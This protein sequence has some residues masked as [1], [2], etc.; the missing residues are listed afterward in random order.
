MF[1]SWSCF[2]SAFWQ[3]VRV[4]SHDWIYAKEDLCAS[5][6][7]PRERRG[8]I[9]EGACQTAPDQ[10]G[11]FGA[12]IAGY[13]LIFYRQLVEVFALDKFTPN[14]IT[15]KHQPEALCIEWRIESSE[16]LDAS[17]FVVA[18]SGEYIP[19]DEMIFMQISLA[20]PHIGED[21]PS[22]AAYNSCQKSQQR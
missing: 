10:W 8:D 20:T 17:A 16:I 19:A 6:Y 12:D 5:A 4:H 15:L 14:S 9:W 2:I 3:I 18:W 7:L 11:I 22:N 13:E 21:S 1:L